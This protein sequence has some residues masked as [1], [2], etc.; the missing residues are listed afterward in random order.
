[1]ERDGTLIAPQDNLPTLGHLGSLNRGVPDVEACQTY[2]AKA[3]PPPPAPPPLPPLTLKQ[4]NHPCESLCI[5]GPALAS[6]QHKG[7]TTVQQRTLAWG[8]Q[9]GLQ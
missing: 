6:G 3:S 7:A 2:A 8:G 1:M 9:W 4:S 5:P